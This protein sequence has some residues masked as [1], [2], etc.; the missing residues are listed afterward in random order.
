MRVGS[1]GS[2]GWPTFRHFNKATG[3]EGVP[4]TE[5]K[6]TDQAMCDEM[7][8]DKYMEGYIMEAGPTSKCN[9]NTLKGCGPRETKYIAKKKAK[10]PGKYQSE[11]SRLTKMSSKSMKPSLLAWI[12][13]R[14]TLLKQLVGDKTEL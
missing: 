10:G 9:V 13:T 4:Y 14:I 7:K 6:K 5:L 8:Q 2:G 1:P 11:I 12:G 3:P